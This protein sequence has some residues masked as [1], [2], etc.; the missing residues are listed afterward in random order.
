MTHWKKSQRSHPETIS[1]FCATTFHA[2]KALGSIDWN[3]EPEWT[4]ADAGF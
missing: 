1:T 3:F 2:V 4:G